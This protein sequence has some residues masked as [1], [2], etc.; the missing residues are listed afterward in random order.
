[1]VASLCFYFWFSSLCP[2]NTFLHFLCDLGQVSWLLWVLLSSATQPQSLS[3]SEDLRKGMKKICPGLRGSLRF[4]PLGAAWPHWN[5]SL[6][7]DKSLNSAPQWNKNIYLLELYI[8]VNE[9][10]GAGNSTSYAF[11]VLSS[12]DL[13]SIRSPCH[14]K[15]HTLDVQ[16]WVVTS[17]S[18]LV[19][20]QLDIIIGCV[21]I[22]I[23]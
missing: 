23:P 12:Y 5:P 1:M 17:L 8:S 13:F 18:L 15:Q 9:W 21:W 20:Q 11:P 3:T 19:A 10:K 22:W 14:N 7:S 16:Q 4:R 2:S 6:T